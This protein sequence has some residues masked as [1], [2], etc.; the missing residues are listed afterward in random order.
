[1]INASQE[2]VNYG[3][4]DFQDYLTR[5]ALIEIFE[6][7]FKEYPLYAKEIIRY[8]VYTN[9]I[10][11][12]L[13]VLGADWLQTKKRI[14]EHCNLPP[15]ED[16]LQD[17][18]FLKSDFIKSSALKWLEFQDDETFSELLMLKNLK[19]EMQLSANS[20]IRK[21]SG[22]IDYD[23]KM[24]NAE[25]SIKLTNLI[26]D[27]QLNLIQNNAKLK[28]A[29]KDAGQNAR[30]TKSSFGVESFAKKPA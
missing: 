25:Y 12:E 5:L 29:H 4:D 14:Y 11:S 26:K 21:A 30:K 27:T 28:E 10:D 24:K 15:K 3:G 23:Q 22:E 16:M 7:V 20:E 17:V 1:M 8:I 19:V 13:I 18:I 6:P 2:I 9:S